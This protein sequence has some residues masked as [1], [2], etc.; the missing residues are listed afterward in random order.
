MF[1]YSPFVF[2]YL[3]KIFFLPTIAMPSAETTDSISQRAILLSSPVLGAVLVLAV[4]L[5]IPLITRAD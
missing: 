3:P 1:F 2:I 4:V 5:A